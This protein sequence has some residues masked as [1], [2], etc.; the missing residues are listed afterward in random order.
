M[1]TNYDMATAVANGA[2]RGEVFCH[3]GA[4]CNATP[5]CLVGFIAI[6]TAAI[7]SS[8]CVTVKPYQRELLSKPC[9]AQ[10]ELPLL[11]RQAA[12]MQEFREGSIGGTGVGVGG[13]GCN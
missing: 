5:R 11:G 8:A 2:R 9:M 4:M 12:H 6:A 3:A 1:G 10:D 7:I 13:C